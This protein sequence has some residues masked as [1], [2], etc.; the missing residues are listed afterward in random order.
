MTSFNPPVEITA[1]AS[2]LCRGGLVDTD[3]N[4]ER[5]VCVQDARTP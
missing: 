4:T 5:D 1:A 2:E 3:L